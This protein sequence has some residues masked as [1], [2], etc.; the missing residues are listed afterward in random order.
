M[1]QTQINRNSIS[2]HTFFYISTQLPPRSLHF[3]HT[4]ADTVTALESFFHNDSLVSVICRFKL[5]TL[6]LLLH[7]NKPKVITCRCFCSFCE[8]FSILWIFNYAYMEINSVP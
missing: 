1:L 5:V 2:Q 4:F 7:P 3:S 8:I 6:K